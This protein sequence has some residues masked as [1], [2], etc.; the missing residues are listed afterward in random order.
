MFNWATQ[1]YLKY[2]FRDM[3]KECFALKKRILSCNLCTDMSG[4]KENGLKYGF[5]KHESKISILIIGESP[6]RIGFFYDLTTKYSRFREKIFE[7]L[8]KS[9]FGEIT[10]LE[11]FES[12]GFYLVDTINCRWDKKMNHKLQKSTFTKCSNFLATQI[13][14]L[15]PKAIITLGN[16]AREALWFENVKDEIDRLGIQ[17]KNI[18]TLQFPIGAGKY[19]T[20]TDASRIRKLKILRSSISINKSISEK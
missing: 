14:I 1:K 3:K 8:S 7:L 19:L 20:E 12:Y 13:S 18:I 10:T 6:P 16:F 4:L 17:F 15:K 5:P 11:E 9:G 2:V